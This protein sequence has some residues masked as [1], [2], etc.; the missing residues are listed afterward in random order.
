MPSPCR[1]HT[2]NSTKVYPFPTLVN[3]AAIDDVEFLKVAELITDSKFIC[4][5]GDGSADASIQEQDMWY[6]RQSTGGSD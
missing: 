2:S 4:K 6:I 3:I 1:P 5:I